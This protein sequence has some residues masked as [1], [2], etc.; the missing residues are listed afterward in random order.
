MKVFRCSD[1]CAQQLTREIVQL[2]NHPEMNEATKNVG[3]SNSLAEHLKPITLLSEITVPLSSAG[4]RADCER[5][6]EARQSLHFH[7]D[8]HDARVWLEPYEGS[9]RR[10]DALP[11][12]ARRATPPFRRGRCMT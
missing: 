7:D 11:P 5:E 6:N 8:R 4:A 12:R 2:S 9:P 10:S 1:D 3:F